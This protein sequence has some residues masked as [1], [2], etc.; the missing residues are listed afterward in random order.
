LN[1]ETR[2]VV[3]DTALEFNYGETFE[4][5][6]IVRRTSGFTDRDRVLFVIRDKNNN[7][8]IWWKLYEL[9]ELPDHDEPT[10]TFTV[11]IPH[12]DSE[13]LIPAAKI[14]KWGIS[15]Y[16]DCI[17]VDGRPVDGIVHMPIPMAD[18]TVNPSVPREEGLA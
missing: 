6:F 9:E 1:D 5:T 14:Y 11:S 2:R 12:E 10:Y 13:A 4:Q 15:F 18:L 16:E 7:S 8:V 17:I 3:M